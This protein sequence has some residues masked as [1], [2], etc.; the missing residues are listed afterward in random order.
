M[1][2]FMFEG[3]NQPT[4]N[5]LKSTQKWMKMQ[6]QNE[7]LICM[8]N[9]NKNT[10][11]QFHLHNPELYKWNYITSSSL[12]LRNPLCPDFRGNTLPSNLFIGSK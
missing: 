1:F 4:Q 5:Q 8:K 9:K 6:P 3:K 7:Q 11:D 12:L 2:Y 10:Y